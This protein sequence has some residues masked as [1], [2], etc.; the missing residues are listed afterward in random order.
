MFIYLIND[1]TLSTGI[2]LCS[3]FVSRCASIYTAFTKKDKSFTKLWI[4]T[5]L[6]LC[7]LK[8]YLLIF[9][10]LHF[11]VLRYYHAYLEILTVS[12]SS[13]YCVQFSLYYPIFYVICMLIFVHCVL[14][15]TVCFSPKTINFDSGILISLFILVATTS[16]PHTKLQSKC[17][18]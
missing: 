12:V 5:S 7:L 18:A 11:P 6:I 2:L 3:P 14:L 16:F 17:S 9:P 13:K 8:I 10:F 1:Y 4:F 15:V